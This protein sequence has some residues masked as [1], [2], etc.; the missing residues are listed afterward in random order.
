MV[1]VSMHINL[2]IF[3]FGEF[4]NTLKSNLKIPKMSDHHENQ[5][6]LLLTKQVQ[7]LANVNYYYHIQI[8]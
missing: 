5:D 2:I 1:Y 6:S 7:H 3:Y 4:L 8:L